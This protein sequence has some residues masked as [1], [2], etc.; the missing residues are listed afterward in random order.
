MIG[1]RN[2]SWTVYSCSSK[3]I[4]TTLNTTFGSHSFIVRGDAVLKSL[5]AQL[6]K[7]VCGNFAWNVPA[8]AQKPDFV[9]RRNG[10]VHLNRQGSQFSRLLATEVCARAIVMLHTPSSEVV[11]KILATHSIRHFPLH[12]PF[13]PSPCAIMFQTKSTCTSP[14][15]LLRMCH[16]MHKSYLA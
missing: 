10:R 12:F 4:F 13:R 5:H 15:I 14:W 3:A 11:W 7:C 16:I 9:F 1:V 2:K 6:C 8:Q